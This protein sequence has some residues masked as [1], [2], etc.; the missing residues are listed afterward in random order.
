M[1]DPLYIAPG[2]SHGLRALPWA[3][4]SALATACIV[5]ICAIRSSP[6]LF[7]EL[8][9]KQSPLRPLV[10]R[11]A[12]TL[13]MDRGARHPVHPSSPARTR[14]APS[15][16]GVLHLGSLRTALYNYLLARQTQGQFVI[17]LEDTDQKRLVPGAEENIYQSLEWAGITADE[18][19]LL[20]GP[21]GPYRQSERGHIY[22]KY[23]DILLAKGLAYKCYCSKDRLN[24]LRESAHRLKPPTTVTYDRSCLHHNHAAGKEHV[25]RFKSPERYPKITDLRHGTLDLQPQYNLSDR[26]YDDFVIMKLDGLP[27]YHFAN[28]VDDHLMKIT[29]V[30]RGEEWLSSTPKHVAL[31]QAFGWSPPAFVHIPLLTSLEDKKLSKRQGD[32]GVLSFISKGV[33]PQALV[34]FVALFGWSPPRPE[35]GKK[36]KEV[37]TLAEMTEKFRL[38]NMTKGNAKVSENKLMFFNKHHLLTILKDPVQLATIVDLEYPHFQ[39]RTNGRFE[40]LYFA[41]CLS[42]AAGHLEK[43]SDLLDQHPYLFYDVDFL[44]LDASK[45]EVSLAI[46]KKTLS[47]ALAQN[48]IVSPSTIAEHFPETSISNIMKTLRFAL[49]GSV[50]GVNVADTLHVLGYDTYVT[51]LQNAINHLESPESHC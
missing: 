31:Y 17:R 26:R 24:S 34:N 22:K 18:S 2:G 44:G 51:R 37:L 11:L 33:V 42:I 7:L 9:P 47:L 25:V 13:E 23:V 20:G 27:T 43:A 48:D 40:K 50:P 36:V 12:G 19:P 29:H 30:I 15:P 46:L 21:Y 14:F 16:T 39:T 45:S 4:D 10:G 6:R 1:Q 8:R 35:R 3:P 41:R 5:M 32:M 49:T 28:V 38:D